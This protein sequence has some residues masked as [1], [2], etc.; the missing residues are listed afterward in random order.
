MG[1]DCAAN[2]G[3]CQLLPALAAGDRQKKGLGH[4]WSAAPVRHKT[5]PWGAELW[6]AHPAPSSGSL[7]GLTARP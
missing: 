4:P 2:E 5:K 7:L 1:R 3:F 6:G